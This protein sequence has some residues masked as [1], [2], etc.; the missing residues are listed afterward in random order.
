[1]CGKSMQHS[2]MKKARAN[3]TIVSQHSYSRMR[4]KVEEASLS[5]PKVA[6]KIPES[7]SAFCKIVSLTAAKTNLIFDVSVACVKCG[8]RFKCALLT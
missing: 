6:H 8:Y 7:L 3:L 1:M 4:W 2:S 5:V